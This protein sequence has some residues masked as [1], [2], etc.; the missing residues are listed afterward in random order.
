[1]MEVI[2]YPWE[3][4]VLCPYLKTTESL[5]THQKVTH[6]PSVCLSGTNI[7]R[8]ELITHITKYECHRNI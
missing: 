3:I 2:V 4:S 6:P 7:G 1:M 8:Y 5:P